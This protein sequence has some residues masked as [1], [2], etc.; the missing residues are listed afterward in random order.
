[1]VE[2]MENKIRNTLNDIYFG[3]TKDIVNGLRSVVP[4]EVALRTAALQHD[5]ALALQRRHVQR[6][7]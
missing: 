7:D 6:D 2:D 1:M 4:A 5:L 3:K